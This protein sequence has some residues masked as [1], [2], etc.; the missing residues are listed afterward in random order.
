MIINI[1]IGWSVLTTIV[2]LVMI[3][4]NGERQARID[5]IELDIEQNKIYDTIIEE[6]EYKYIMGHH[7]MRNEEWR[8]VTIKEAIQCLYKRLNF[9]L[10]YTPEKT[11][12]T[13]EDVSIK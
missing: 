8:S 2:I 5:K 11:E 10:T 9:H 1:L 6:H 13:S 3:A 4:N 7:Y 12:T